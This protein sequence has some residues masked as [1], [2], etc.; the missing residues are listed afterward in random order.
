MNT[1]PA[2]DSRNDKI[3]T[4]VGL[5]VLLL[6]TAT[7]DAYAML[8]MSV[9]ALFVMAVFLREGRGRAVLLTLAVAAMTGAL[10]AVGVASS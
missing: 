8:V 4:T 9:F 10:V 7:G 1:V 6:G 5:L 3:V 2:H